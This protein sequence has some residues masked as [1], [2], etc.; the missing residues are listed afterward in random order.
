MNEPQTVSIEARSARIDVEG[1]VVCDRL[2]LS[3]SGRRLVLAGPPAAA[4]TAALCARG[5]IEQGALFIDGRDVAAGEHIGYVGLAPFDLP[6]P[7]RDTVL[8]FVTV[9]FRLAGLGRVEAAAA[10]HAALSELGLDA[11]AARKASSLSAAERKAA[12]IAQ[13]MIPKAPVLMIESPLHGL[14]SSDASR[15]L[16]LLARV[17]RSRAVIAT[18][19]RTDPGSPER[20]LLLGADRAAILTVQGCCWIGDPNTLMRGS[21]LFALTVQG[22]RFGECAAREGLELFGAYPH[23]TV[24]LPQGASTSVLLNAAGQADATLLDLVPL[25]D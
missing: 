9:S 3:I 23:F 21:R 13:A 6:L 24:C 18:A 25:W 17:C 4:L 22:P 7:H 8:A 1:A 14:E 12:T 10:A 16:E 20:Q 5:S 2:S 19:S 15:V 11:L